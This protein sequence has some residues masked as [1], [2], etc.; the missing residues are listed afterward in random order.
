MVG[1]REGLNLLRLNRR[2]ALFISAFIAYLYDIRK[3]L[4]LIISARPFPPQAEGKMGKM[5]ADR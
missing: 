1:V 3:M 4:S 5:T 2:T